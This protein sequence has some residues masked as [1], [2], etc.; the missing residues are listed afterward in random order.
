VVR[1]SIFVYAAE[2][3]VAA[4]DFDGLE[5]GLESRDSSAAGCKRAYVAFFLENSATPRACH[6][7]VLAL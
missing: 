1:A 7:S 6:V 3:G 4:W 5:H 2:F